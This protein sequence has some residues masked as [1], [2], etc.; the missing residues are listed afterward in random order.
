MIRDN[1]LS[2]ALLLQT[3][4]YSYSLIGIFHFFDTDASEE[5]L[6]AVLSEHRNGME[7]PTAFASGTVPAGERK[8]HSC[9][10]EAAVWGV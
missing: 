1:K 4:P 6:G 10:F 9:E 7:E 3:Q 2:I 5:G 8:W